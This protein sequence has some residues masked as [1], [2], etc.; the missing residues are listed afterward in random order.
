MFIRNERLSEFTRWYPVVTAL[1]I[2]H[3]ITYL[4][5]IF[6]FLPNS[7]MFRMFAGTNLY[8]E[9]GEWWRLITPI[10]LHNGFGHFIF[11]TFSLVIFAPPLE[12]A[13]GK[14]R[15]ILTYLGT[16]ILANIMTFFAES[17]TYSHV[18]SSGAIYGLLGVYLA[19]ILF[20]K[21]LIPR[22]SSQTV[23]PIL[24]L[25]FIMT[26]I[27]PQI[28]IIAHVGGCI[29]GLAFGYFWIQRNKLHFY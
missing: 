5:T 11:N 9:L 7:W 19:V 23:L 24:A 12:R 17:P 2:V 14:G 8:I 22:H 10:F 26:F 27:Q 16:G 21:H 4:L 1:V 15:F 13:L 25:G 6:P 18:G 28:N 29:I 20:A 3:V